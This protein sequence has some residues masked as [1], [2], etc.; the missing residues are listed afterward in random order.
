MNNGRVNRDRY[1]RCP[2]VFRPWLADDGALV[3]LRLAGRPLARLRDVLSIAETFGDGDVHLTTRANVQIR[4]IAP[5]GDGVSDDFVEA[6]RDVGLLPEPSHELVRNIAISPLSG[7]AGGRGDIRP[8]ATELDRLLCADPAFAN[9]AGRF[10]F[11]LDDGRGDVA[12]TN[13]DLGLIC[14]DSASAQ[15]RIGRELFGPVV[16]L[17][18]AAAVLVAIARRFLEL[19]GTGPSAVWHVDELGVEKRS[20][21]AKSQEADPRTHVRSEPWPEGLITQD[22]GRQARHIPIHEGR[23]HRDLLN[24]LE[25]PDTLIVTPWRSV[26]IPDLEAS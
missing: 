3:R 2:G 16:P 17:G 23:L 9:L 18:E 5:S 7:R 10:L 1:D 15:V 6:V 20:A 21:L 26:I 22:D 25:L 8:V 14:L 19:R 12:D 4:G 24:H 11:V 13:L